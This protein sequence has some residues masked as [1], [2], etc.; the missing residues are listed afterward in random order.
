VLFLIGGIC[1]IVIEKRETMD[2]LRN[3]AAHIERIQ[4]Q[5]VPTISPVKK[6]R[7]ESGFETEA[8]RHCQHVH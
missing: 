4:K 3:I 8:L 7:K 2:V 1:G 6:N 5:S